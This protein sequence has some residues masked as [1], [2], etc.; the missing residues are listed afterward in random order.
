[1]TERSAALV[2][3]IIATEISMKK[4]SLSRNLKEMIAEMRHPTKGW[5]FP[6]C[7]NQLVTFFHDGLL[8]SDIAELLG[9]TK[10]N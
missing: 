3:F 6:K 2:Q 4:K 5:P 1:M 7:P 8:P 10:Q 9:L